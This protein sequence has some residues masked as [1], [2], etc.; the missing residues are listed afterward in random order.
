[1]RRL[2]LWREDRSLKEVTYK[3]C[4]LGGMDQLQSYLHPSGTWRVL[5][6]W[7]TAASQLLNRKDDML[8]PAF[9]PS[10]GSS[11]PDGAGG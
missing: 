3:V 7:Q 8:Q 9:V 1:M 11:L 5:E 4:V 6:R 10:I 2:L